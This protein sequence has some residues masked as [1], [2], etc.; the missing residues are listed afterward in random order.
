[1]SSRTILIGFSGVSLPLADMPFVRDGSASGLR[2]ELTFPPAISSVGAWTSLITGHSPAQHGIFDFYRRQSARGQQLRVLASRDI[3]GETMW[4]ALDRQ[5]LKAT[6]LNY[7]MT[8]PAPKIEGQV[9]PGSWVSPKRLALGCYPSDLCRQLGTL[10]GVDVN[11]LTAEPLLRMLVH[12]LEKEPSDLSVVLIRDKG[13]LDFAAIDL[14]LERVVQAAGPDATLLLISEP[15]VDTKGFSANA[16]LA[17]HGYLAWAS[18]SNPGA[19]DGKVLET[20]DLNRQAALIDWTKTR[21]WSPPSGGNGI[22][23]V[24]QDAKSPAGVS[25]EEYEGFRTRLMQELSATPA[26]SRVWKQEDLYAGPFQELAPDLMLEWSGNARGIVLGR[27]P[28]LKRGTVSG[29]TLSGITPL[30]LYTLGLQVPDD[31]EGSIPSEILDPAW[32]ESHPAVSGE[33]SQDREPDKP[34]IDPKDEEEI[35]RRLRGL[36]YLE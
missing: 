34:L 35:L 36:G 27:G 17:E 25:D 14:Y 18:S 16:W 33:A 23:I 15:L 6:I 12:L 4:S 28:A 1:M 5:G 31:I 7:P 3:S 2:A 8:F 22:F 11:D 10:E 29:L 20:S 13:P 9:L 26:I 30:L 21:A 19:V 32:M 24:R